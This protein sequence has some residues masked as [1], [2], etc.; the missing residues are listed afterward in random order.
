MHKLGFLFGLILL[1]GLAT[2][3]QAQETPKAEVFG[4]YSFVR[5]KPQTKRVQPFLQTS[6]ANGG[7]ASIA[8]NLNHWFGVVADIGGYKPD[9]TS[10]GTVVSYLFGPRLS[11]RAKARYTPFVQVLFGGAHASQEVFVTPNTQN[12]FAMTAGGGV[13][14]KVTDKVSFRTAQVEYLLTR[15]DEGVIHDKGQNGMRVS[16]G[17]VFRF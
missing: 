15:F 2:A 11:Y 1:L 10:G 17:I 8:Y 6:N 16:T 3:A 7:S 9:T 12:K 5:S 13:D 14:W 4:G